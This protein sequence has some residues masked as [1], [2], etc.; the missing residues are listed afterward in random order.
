MVQTARSGLVPIGSFARVRH[1]ERGNRGL[2]PPS[3]RSCSAHS[4]KP[5]RGDLWGSHLGDAS[6]PTGVGHDQL[7]PT[8][9]S[10]RNRPCGSLRPGSAVLAGLVPVNVMAP[11]SAPRQIGDGKREGTQA[12]ETD[13]LTLVV[14]SYEDPTV[15]AHA[16][17]IVAQA[18][19]MNDP[20]K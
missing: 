6:G 12:A 16:L 2:A 7:L 13:D 5:Q 1:S 17:G 19:D 3:C 18:K 10:I 8:V 9:V 15:L 20:A 4:K 14:D 11:S